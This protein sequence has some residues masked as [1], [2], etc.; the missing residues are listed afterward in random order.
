MIYFPPNSSTACAI[1]SSSV[2]T[3]VL[4]ITLET[5]SYTCCIMGFPARIA[6]GFAGN[7]VDAY[8]AGIIAMN[9]INKRLREVEEGLEKVGKCSV[10]Y[11]SLGAISLSKYIIPSVILFFI[12]CGYFG[13]L[14]VAFA[15]GRVFFLWCFT[16]RLRGRLSFVGIIGVKLSFGVVS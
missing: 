1:L 12:S 4:E 6:K 8:R 13:L 9:F 11:R 3:K 14:A 2:A 10:Y 7:R 15:C 5:R 16:F